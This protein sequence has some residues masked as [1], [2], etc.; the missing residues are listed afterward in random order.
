MEKGTTTLLPSSKRWH[1][2]LTDYIVFRHFFRY[3]YPIQ[4]KWE[5][6]QPLV[7]RLNLVWQKFETQMTKYV[8]DRD[9]G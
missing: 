1:Q 8:E 7:K 2:E 4:L 9:S 6:L 5:L 3:S